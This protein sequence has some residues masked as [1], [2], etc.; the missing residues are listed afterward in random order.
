VPLRYPGFIAIL[1]TDVV[2]GDLF[3]FVLLFVLGI[4]VVVLIS[5][6]F[7]RFVLLGFRVV[8]SFGVVL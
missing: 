7:R 6:Y 3:W 5:A 8:R 2:V 1:Y 4:Y